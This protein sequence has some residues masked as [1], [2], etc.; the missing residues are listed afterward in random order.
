MFRNPRATFLPTPGRN[1]SMFEQLEGRQLMA[2]SLQI[3]Q[4][5]TSVGPAL[6]INGTGRSDR[7][8]I[9]RTSKGVSVC[10]GRTTTSVAGGTFGTIIVNG[11]AGNDR[12]TISGSLKLNA[13][14][15]GGAGNDVGNGGAGRDT[16][17]GND[18]KDTLRG[19]TGRD[20]VHGGDGADFLR[21]GAPTAAPGDAGN[22]GNGAD[23]CGGFEV[24][25]NC[26]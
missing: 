24:Q 4:Q 13:I 10:D 12:I 22:G 25:V 7:I 2:S 21:G 20:R 3:F 26:P 18:G 23:N 17:A 1:V 15:N 9:N 16:I 14:I 11:G 19:S 6:V 8:T 5:Q